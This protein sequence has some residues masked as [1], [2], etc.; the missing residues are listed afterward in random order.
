MGKFISITYDYRISIK[1][2]QVRSF[3]FGVPALPLKRP[4]SFWNPQYS[5][6]T[7]EFCPEV[8]LSYV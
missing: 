1:L 6:Q 7:S 3:P 5:L 2:T 8:Q 4:A